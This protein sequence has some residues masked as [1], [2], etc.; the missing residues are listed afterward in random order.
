[1]RCHYAT[2]GGAYLCTKH[3]IPGR[4]TRLYRGYQ[5]RHHS[6][7]PRIRDV[8]R[9]DTSF[10]ITGSETSP[11]ATSTRPFSIAGCISAISALAFCGTMITLPIVTSGFATLKGLEAI[12]SGAGP[13]KRSLVA[14]GSAMVGRWVG[15]RIL[16]RAGL[17]CRVEMGGHTVYDL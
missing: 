9:R 5:Q 14:G 15:N 1:M 7:Y 8:P 13:L 12:D 16:K 4:S 17:S 11:D 10:S 2:E 3:S 6:F